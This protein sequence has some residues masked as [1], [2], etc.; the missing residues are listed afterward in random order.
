M[1]AAHAVERVVVEDDDGLVRGQLHVQLDA[2]SALGGGAER[3]QAVLGYGAVLRMQ[4]A[5]RAVQPV[6][7]ARARGRA[8]VRGE[9]KQDKRR[10]Q[11]QHNDDSE[12]ERHKRHLIP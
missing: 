12:K 1:H 7:D 9:K 6:K 2:V 3:G 11:H 10:E 5:V 8:A 4:T